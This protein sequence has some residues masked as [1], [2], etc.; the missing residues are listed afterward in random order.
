MARSKDPWSP[1]YNHVWTIAL[2]LKD[3]ESYELPCDTLQEANNLRLTYYSW[4]SAATK[5]FA[6]RGDNPDDLHDVYGPFNAFL[7]V[8]ND[9][10]R[11]VV[12][13]RNV[14]DMELRIERAAE[15]SRQQAIKEKGDTN[16]GETNQT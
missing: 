10:P 14:S 9:P 12:S 3:L 7:Q 2:P 11:L 5:F 4:R 8:K 6:Q 16:S 1:S 13:R 15:L